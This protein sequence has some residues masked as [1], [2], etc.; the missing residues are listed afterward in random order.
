ME[1]GDF[2]AQKHTLDNTQFVLHTMKEPDYVMMLMSMY[3]SENRMGRNNKREGTC[4]TMASFQYPEVIHNHFAYCNSVDNHNSRRMHPIA[5]KE[6]CRTSR[7]SYWCFQFLI[8]VTEVN[9]NL[10]N[11]H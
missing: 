7:W 8:A 6:Q 10:V 4:G 5:I 3:G 2:D 1:V 9:C 11:H